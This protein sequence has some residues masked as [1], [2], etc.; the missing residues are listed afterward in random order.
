MGNDFAAFAHYSVKYAKADKLS[1][2]LIE[3]RGIRFCSDGTITVPT[4]SREGH[5]IGKRTIAKGR[6]PFQMFLILK[7]IYETPDSA[8]GGNA[9][10]SKGQ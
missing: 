7:N 5:V 2:N 4:L 9:S 3:F 6:T 10:L 8:G 1:D